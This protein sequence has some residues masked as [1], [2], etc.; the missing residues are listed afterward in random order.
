MLTIFNLG[1]FTAANGNIEIRDCGPCEES[2][3]WVYVL[4][5]FGFGFSQC[6]EWLVGEAL[7][8]AIG[9]RG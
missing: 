5:G 3:I 7:N 1:S 9:G 8:G 4:F 2:A 6:T